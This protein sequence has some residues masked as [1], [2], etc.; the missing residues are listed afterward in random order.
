MPALGKRIFSCALS[1]LILVSEDCIL[2]HTSIHNE[3]YILCIDVLLV[4]VQKFVCIGSSHWFLCTWCVSHTKHF[5]LSFIPL[6]RSNKSALS[7]CLLDYILCV[8]SFFLSIHKPFIVN[9]HEHPWRANHAFAY[10]LIQE[11]SFD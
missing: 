9:T 7:V 11:V 5:L 6:P 8:V 4:I 3:S 10:T 2:H 1:K